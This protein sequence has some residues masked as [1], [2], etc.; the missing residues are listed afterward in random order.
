MDYESLYQEFKFKQMAERQ[1]QL[2]QNNHIQE[3]S[4]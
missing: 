4:N 3:M 1:A 2:A